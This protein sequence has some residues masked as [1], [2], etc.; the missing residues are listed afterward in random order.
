MQVLHLTKI[1]FPVLIIQVLGADLK[2]R[3]VM[4]PKEVNMFVV[5]FRNLV[6]KIYNLHIPVI[7]A[8][9]GIAVGIRA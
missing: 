2:E 3:A 8:I 1:I 9:D 6:H 7:S 4:T 5:S